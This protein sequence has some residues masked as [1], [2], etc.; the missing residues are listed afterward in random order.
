MGS[1]NP[2]TLLTIFPMFFLAN[3]LSCG[4]VKVFWQEKSML[5]IIYR[6]DTQ[7]ESDKI[8]V[9]S[10]CPKTYVSHK[11]VT[12]QQIVNAYIDQFNQEAVLYSTIQA[13]SQH[14]LFFVETLAFFFHRYLSL[15]HHSHPDSCV[16]AYY[17][18]SETTSW[19]VPDIAYVALA[20]SSFCLVA[21]FGL[22]VLILVR[23]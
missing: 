13:G 6:P 17:C 23:K 7:E 10:L 9:S 21:V 22:L 12:S 14:T 3:F 8:L 1:G 18:L 16:T 4:A 11:F 19:N 15:S 2:W 20:F 5:I